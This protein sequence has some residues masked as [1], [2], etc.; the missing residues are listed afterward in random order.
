MPKEIYPH[1]PV[2]FVAFEIQYALTPALARAD[3]K[4]AV[5]E[6]LAEGFPLLE[7]L[8]TVPL[9]FSLAGLEDLTPQSFAV[10]VVAGDQLRMTDRQRTTSVT[11]GPRSTVIA[12]GDHS[13]FDDLLPIIRGAL[14]AVAEV[15]VVRGVERLSLRY[16]NEIRHPAV[17]TT[18]DWAELLAPG[19][20]APPALLDADVV[21]THGMV[22][23]RLSDQHSVRLIFGAEP[24]GFAVDPRGPLRVRVHDAGPFFRLDTESTWIAPSD[25]T[26][27]LVV[28]EVVTMCEMLHAPITAI[29]EAAIS[30][31]LRD[32]FRR[33]NDA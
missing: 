21:R 26:A 12:H 16:V 20:G 10:P 3:G 23:Y 1:A 30:S 5:Y 2:Q 14:Q 17:S 24:E 31:T 4:E 8:S 11:V 7:S 9:Q 27:P 32:F 25:A 19:L 18:T 22:D 6:R 13:S 33:P 28:E 29:F 15:S